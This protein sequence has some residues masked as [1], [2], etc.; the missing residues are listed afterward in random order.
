[1]SL[2]PVIG[3]V[4][5]LVTFPFYLPKF[6][7]IFFPTNTEHLGYLKRH[8]KL[9]AADVVYDIGCGNGRVL[10]ELVRNTHAR[11]VGIELSPLIYMAGK[12]NLAGTKNVKIAYGDIFKKDL[13]ESTVLYCFLNK[14]VLEKL[15][16]KFKK[17]LSS[18]T[19]IISYIFKIPGLEEIE[20][21]RDPKGQVLFYV[22]EI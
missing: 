18:K 21:V 6:R 2:I 4:L 13:R 5:L 7:V 1:M 17:E 3:L 22:Y 20:M 14:E 19:K 11:G 8:L 16:P 10:K 15:V 9:T 12:L